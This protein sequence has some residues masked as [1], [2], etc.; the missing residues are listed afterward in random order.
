[1]NL[2]ELKHIW[3]AHTST[4]ATHEQRS[5]A[6]IQ[7]ML[8]QR[9]RTALSRINRNILMEAGF[10]VLT[11]GISLWML[12]QPADLLRGMWMFFILL[13]LGSLVF[14]RIKYRQLNQAGLGRTNLKTSLGDIAQ[15]MEHY[16]QLYGFLGMVV[17]PLLG[18]VGVVYGYAAGAKEDGRTLVD[19][20]LAEWGILAGIALLYGLACYFATRFYVHRLYGV[21]YRELRAC[22]AELTDQ[23]PSTTSPSQ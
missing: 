16:M 22:L 13:S 10:M 6:E 18:V 2:D 23:P 1:M 7:Q 12:T 21:H 11:L 20:S 5:T 14:Y 4:Q 15:V 9:S 17:I 8:Y 19:L 3:E